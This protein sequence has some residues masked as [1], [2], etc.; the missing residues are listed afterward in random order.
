MRPRSLARHTRRATNALVLMACALLL[1]TTPAAAR[2]AYD[3]P[4]GTPAAHAQTTPDKPVTVRYT[5]V[6]NNNGG[7]GTLGFALIAVGAVAALLGAGY[8]GAR[9]ASDH[10]HHPAT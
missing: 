10:G 7:L 3:A 8:L 9:I 2:V 5:V 6:P 1:A 4:L